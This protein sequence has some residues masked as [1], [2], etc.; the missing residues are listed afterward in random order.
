M[1]RRKWDARTK[2]LIVLQGLT[3]LE[4]FVDTYLIRSESDE[5]CGKTPG[6]FG[7]GLL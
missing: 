5:R 6:I 4:N 7:T 3:K 1:P 2:A